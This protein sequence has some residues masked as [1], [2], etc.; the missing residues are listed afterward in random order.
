MTKAEA[1]R[2]NYKELDTPTLLQWYA[3]TRATCGCGGRHKGF[4]N[5]DL[6]EKYAL[7]LRERGVY[8]PKNI[9]EHFDKKFVTNVEVPKGTFNG[10]GSY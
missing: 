8:V 2:M 7:E 1:A 9:F 10:V 3:N 5:D 4:M 6:Y